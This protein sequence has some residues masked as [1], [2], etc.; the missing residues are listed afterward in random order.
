M[1]TMTIHARLRSREGAVR[2]W[3]AGG[4][5]VSHGGGEVFHGPLARKGEAMSAAAM[6]TYAYDQI[7]QARAQVKA[8]A[9]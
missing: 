6:V 4:Q 3:A 8:V 5:L 9:K 1:S 2:A 7:D